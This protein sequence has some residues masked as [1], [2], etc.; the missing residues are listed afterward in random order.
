MRCWL[1]WCAARGRTGLSVASQKYAIIA[2]AA[3]Q[4]GDLDV[5]TLAAMKVYANV[6][7]PKGFQVQKTP[8]GQLP[9]KFTD[10]RTGM[11]MSGLIVTPDKLASTA[12]GFAQAGFDKTLLAAAEPEIT[13]RAFQ[14]DGAVSRSLKRCWTRP[15]FPFST[16]R[17]SVRS[18]R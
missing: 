12:M 18:S 17:L 6:A 11:L 14:G 10:K 2:A 13:R 8:D 7:D 16:F 4:K 5:V 15:E 9:Y 3:D 1:P